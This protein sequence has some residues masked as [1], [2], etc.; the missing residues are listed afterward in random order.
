MTCRR[1]AAF[2][3]P[4]PYRPGP[5]LT[6]DQKVAAETLADAVRAAA[7]PAGTGRSD[8]G[9]ED[10]FS[11]T[12]LDGVTGSGKTEVYFEAIAAALRAGARRW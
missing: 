11:V 4:D 5:V 6:G 7:P 9:A 10:G 12:L 8:V 3:P 2:E 1:R